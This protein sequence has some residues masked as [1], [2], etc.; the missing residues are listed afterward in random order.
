MS[1]RAAH[2]RHV[3]VVLH[4][5]GK[6]TRNVARQRV[7][8]VTEFVSPSCA[9][10]KHR[11]EPFHGGIGKSKEIQ[12]VDPCGGVVGGVGEGCGKRVGG[13]ASSAP[14]GVF[15]PP[16]EIVHGGI[17]NVSVRTNGGRR[18]PI[19][20]GGGGGGSSKM[21]PPTVQLPTMGSPGTCP[22]THHQRFTTPSKTVTTG[23]GCPV[24]R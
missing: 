20:V 23:M 5:Y 12:V 11:G 6:R 10:G 14:P 15:C 21:Q 22:G 24:V 16:S 7:R 19:P 1:R 17:P 13:A 3:A 8:V 9:N 18:Q 2:Q 4:Q